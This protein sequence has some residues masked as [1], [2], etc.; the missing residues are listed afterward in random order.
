MYRSKSMK[1][2]RLEE[3]QRFDREM[4]SIS[5]IDGRAR[6][7]FI[8]SD[9]QRKSQVSWICRSVG[10]VASIFSRSA[11]RRLAVKVKRR[12]TRRKWILEW[13]PFN[14]WCTRSNITSL[15][16]PIFEDNDIEETVVLHV[17]WHCDNLNPLNSFD[18]VI[19][20]VHIGWF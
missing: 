10:T 15:T 19:T 3:R 9:I 11:E 7:T 5:H 13:S 17:R 6:F 1:K 4:Q 14:T 8:A 18:K 2:H 16:L 12:I 20:R